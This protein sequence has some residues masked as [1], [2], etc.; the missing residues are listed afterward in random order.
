MNAARTGA[1]TGTAD[2]IRP[3]R[4]R[5]DPWPIRLLGAA[6]VAVGAA[7]VIAERHHSPGILIVL[8]MTA[9]ALVLSTQR[10][11]VRVSAEGI[12]NVPLIGRARIYP[13]SEINGFA[14]GK[15]PGGYGGPVVSMHLKDRTVYLTATEYRFGGNHAVQQM[16]EALNAELRRAR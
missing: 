2:S 7:T 6:F 8:A 4:Y 16:C 11:G 14:V 9:G 5:R 12:R 3:S 10:S 15:V 13:W 1:G